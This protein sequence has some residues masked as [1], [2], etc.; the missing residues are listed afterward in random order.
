[1]MKDYLVE[2]VL[3]YLAVAGLV[4]LSAIAMIAVGLIFTT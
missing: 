2:L 3:S 1:M 4:L